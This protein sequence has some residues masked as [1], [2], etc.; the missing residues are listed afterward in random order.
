MLPPF[1]LKLTH[2]D[3]IFYYTI[4]FLL[5]QILFYTNPKINVFFCAFSVFQ[6]STV[7]ESFDS[8]TALFSVIL[9]TMT[10]VALLLGG[11]IATIRTSYTFL[12]AFFEFH[13]IRHGA[14]DDQSANEY[15][16]NV[17]HNVK[18]LSVFYSIKLFS[19]HGYF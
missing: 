5:L 3:T 16:D 17:Y 7:V 18:I 2:F 12:S 6:K 11:A 1:L 10:R 4:L 9:M 13:D 14:T 15:H 8:P 19:Q